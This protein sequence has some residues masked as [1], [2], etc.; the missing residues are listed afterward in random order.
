LPLITG[1]TASS[2]PAPQ[3][4]IK[5]NL[6]FDSHGNVVRLTGANR[7]G[8]EYRCLNYSVFDGPNSEASIDAMLQW[9]INAIRIPLNE[10]CWLGINMKGSRFAGDYYRDH[11]LS[12]VD[13]LISNGITP[14]LDL[15]WAAPGTQQATGLEP[16]PDRNHSVTFWKQVAADFKDK[17]EVI[18][19]LFN[20]PYPD[21]NHDTITAWKCWKYGTD[22]V[23]CPAGTAG[24]HYE[25]AGMQELVDAVRDTGAANVIMLGGV[26]YA[27]MLDGWMQF[28]PDDPLNQLAAAWHLYNYSP[29]NLRP[30]WGSQGL[31]V[32]QHFPVI[33]GEMGEDDRGSVFIKRVM[34]FLDHPADGLQPQSYLAWVWNTDQTI[35]DLIKNYKGEP[36]TPYG[37]TYMDHLLSIHP[38]P[39]PGQPGTPDN[40]SFS[41]QLV[42]DRREVP[43][44]NL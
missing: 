26:Q 30:C 11:I 39:A 43:I 36:T 40:R 25:A 7:S 10:D 41:P 15:H 32:M 1:S 9:H 21:N 2:S 28:K 8:T 38:K 35:Y 18:F 24:L 3:L 42:G 27:S 13:M 31:P 17:H 12:Y 23:Y 5:G 4:H 22:P 19:D 34:S 44:Y 16:L 14:I 6:L 29:C 20:E 37:K 33:T